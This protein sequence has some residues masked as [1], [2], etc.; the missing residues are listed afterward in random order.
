MNTQIRNLTYD[1]DAEML[2]IIA[3]TETVISFMCSVIPHVSNLSPCWYTFT[4][5][6]A[7]VYYGYCM[8]P[9][10]TYCL[11]PPP[12]GIDANAYYSSMPAGMMPAHSASPAPPPP[13]TTPPPDS[14]VTVP[15]A[16]TAAAAPPAAPAPLSH[17]TPSG[18]YSTRYVYQTPEYLRF[19]VIYHM[20]LLSN[21]SLKNNNN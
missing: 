17:A 14:A 13:G 12:P 19:L 9:D 1:A 20:S 5:N 18:F 7:A 2:M 6:M 15:S 10:G 11:A 21:F 16:P 4:A 3:H 8:L